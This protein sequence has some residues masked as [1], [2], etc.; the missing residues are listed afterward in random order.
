MSKQTDLKLIWKTVLSEVELEVSKPVFKTLFPQTFLT[1]LKNNS[2]TIACP[3]PVVRQMV[4]NRYA[5]LLKTALSR[6]TK[7]DLSLNFIIK[8]P[9]NNSPKKELGPLFASPPPKKPSP[10]KYGLSP[11]YTF[12]TLIVGNSNNFA[13]AAAQAIVQKPGRA[14]NPFF[15]WGGVG[16]GKTHLIQATGHA[17]L[18]K[19]PSSRVLYVSSETFTNDL[20]R[21]LQ[22]KTITKFKNKYRSADCL[23]IDDIQFISGKEYSQEEFFHTFNALHLSGR[24]IVITSD[25]K[26][27]EISQIEERLTSRFLGGLSVDIQPPDY[28]MRVGIL[29]AKCQ[30]LASPL[31]QSSLEFIAAKIQSNVRELEGTLLQILAQAK[32]KNQSPDLDFIKSFFGSKSSAL[33]SISPKTVISA[34]AKYFNLKQ[35]DLL[36]KSR[37]TEIVLPRQILMFLLRTELKLSLKKIGDI[38]GG[39]DHT[40]VIHAQEKISSLVSSDSKLRQNIIHIKTNLS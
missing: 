21:A 4:K 15:V 3:N 13:H 17:V 28:E 22:E 19:N 26:P 20:V 38:V 8:S 1:S 27:E 9:P 25:R 2:A 11:H 12:K 31:D 36:G 29:R 23:L 33:K 18:E 30:Q 39:R 14:Y 35:A 16:V 32:S 7:K 10:Q 37:K 40:T 24:Q 34:V 5:S 6:Q